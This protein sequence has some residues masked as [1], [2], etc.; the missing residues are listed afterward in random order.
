MEVFALVRPTRP[1][2]FTKRQDCV[3]EP[4]VGYGDL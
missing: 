4:F 2:L 3:F 1:A